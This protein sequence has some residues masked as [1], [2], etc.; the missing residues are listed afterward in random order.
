MRRLGMILVVM[1]G[2]LAGC[3][4]KPAARPAED[5][6]LA[7]VGEECVHGDERKDLVT[8]Q[9]RSGRVTGYETG[10]GKVGVI[11]AHQADG[12]LCQWKIYATYLASKGYRALAINFDVTPF[13]ENVPAAVEAMRREKDIKQVFLVGASMGG[14]AVLQAAAQVQPPVAGVVSLSAPTVYAGMDALAPMPQL[15]VPAFFAAAEGDGRFATDTREMYQAAKVTDKKL[16]ILPGSNHGTALL[17]DELSAQIEQFIKA[18][19]AT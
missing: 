10:S 18:H 15:A 3:G 14:T 4:G 16:V 11:L 7:H 2:T 12:D 9:S 17:N 6:A 13:S 1:L 19:V 8:F 5:P